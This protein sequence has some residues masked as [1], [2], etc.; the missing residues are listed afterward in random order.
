MNSIQRNGPARFLAAEVECH[1]VTIISAPAGHG[2]TLLLAEWARRTGIADKAWVSADGGDNDP[3]RFFATVF[4][5]VRACAVPPPESLL[6][7]VPAAMEPADFAARLA[8]AVDELPGRICLVVDDVHEIADAR[9]RHA[10]ELLIRH[11]PANLRLV[12]AGRSD[13]PLPLA[14]L[15][16]HGKLGEV[17]ARD[18]RFS[19]A[20]AR[21]L[22]RQAGVALEAGQVAR[23][24]EKTGGWAAGLRLAARSLRDTGDDPAGF[25]TRF[26]GD[27]RAVADYL[28]SEVLTGLPGSAREFLRAVSICDEVT[29]AL[30]AVL[31]G[32]PDAAEIL[33]ELEQE[34]SLVTRVGV[35][36]HW[37]RTHPLLRS[38]LQAEL[39]RLHPG[40]AA[41]LHAV[42]AAWLAD[43]RQ[44]G[45]A[46]THA[47]RSREP[48]VLSRLLGRYGLDLLLTG[49]HGT[50][51]RAL[52]LAGPA[53]V[54]GSARLTLLSALAHLET[55]DLKTARARLAETDANA[56]RLGAEAT[57]VRRLLASACAMATGERP[58]QA[59]DVQPAGG[60][61]AWTG[62][63]RGWRLLHENRPREAEAGLR[64]AQELAR[65]YGTD[66]LAMHCLAARSAAA[67]L[68]GDYATMSATSAESLALA[69][70][71]GWESSPWLTTSRI[72]KALGHLLRAEPEDALD[73]ARAARNFAVPAQEALAYVITVIEVLCNGDRVGAA[74]RLREARNRLGDA[75]VLPAVAAAG[76]LAEYRCLL[77]LGQD[78]LAREVL[79]WAHAR[80]GAVAELNL[81]TAWHRF[82]TEDFDGA[83]QALACA[84][85][86]PELLKVLTPL[87]IQL[88]TAAVS[89]R[90]GRRTRAIESLGEAL[91]LAAPARLLRPFTQA[92]R[93]VRLLLV[94]QLGGFDRLDG[95]AR[96]ASR[97]MCG[98][99]G[100][101]LLTDREHAVLGWLAS[102]QSLE[103]LADSLSV[104]V[105]TVKTHVRAIYTK[106]GV[107][108]R[109]AAVT[110]ARERGLA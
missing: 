85:A 79:T 54:S 45:L 55:G 31:S 28:V 4:A 102:P 11:Q 53:E 101:G 39:D 52:E 66:Y 93:A 63:D 5:A 64:Q 13:P 46:F 24:V 97:A 40:A 80:T 60:V 38:Y 42:A 14:R 57:A 68:D 96:E 61:A 104:S 88:L 81:M 58:G 110:T 87:E 6:W 92:D 78:V 56:G 44:I 20:E 59:A 84:S 67:W 15:R 22:F 109:R 8:D 73:L 25:V 26:T 10:I 106:L 34:G 3:D 16:L 35:G 9:C 33:V 75:P 27:D 32:R 91:R 51:L 30:G 29:P 7:S 36:R 77:A 72:T 74:R 105:N 50:V 62:L 19:E 94:D 49:D 1:P 108:S 65:G 90:T 48:A 86:A 89:V 82:A 83:R 103:E 71:N 69:Q 17:R 47:A 95:F 41:R 12:L 21:M 98:E 18:L 43:D 37:Y 99:D 107:S 100:G 76:A 2:K 23:L 70:D